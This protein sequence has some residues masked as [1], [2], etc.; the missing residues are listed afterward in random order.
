MFDGEQRFGEQRNVV[1]NG[2][3]ARVDAKK[4]KKIAFHNN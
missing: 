1:M 4:F 3:K 2:I